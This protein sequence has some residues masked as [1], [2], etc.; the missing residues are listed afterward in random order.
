MVDNLTPHPVKRVI[1]H[2]ATGL[3]LVEGG[4]GTWV[5]SPGA[6]TKY[7][8]IKDMVE[9]CRRYGLEDVELVY[10]L[11]PSHEMMAAGPEG[12]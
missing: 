4:N 12:D 7:G 8:T 3:Y 10:K 6:A 2:K 11:D 9:V 5:E 1:R